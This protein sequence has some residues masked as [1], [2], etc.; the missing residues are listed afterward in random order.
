MSGRRFEL[1]EL[2]L[3]A[4]RKVRDLL[5]QTELGR[6]EASGVLAL[7]G[8]LL[9]I[10]DDTTNIGLIDQDLSP[11]ANNRVIQPDPPLARDKYAGKGYEDI[12]WDP[13]SSSLYLLVESVRHREQLLPRVEIVDAD[14]RRRSQ[15]FLDFPFD[16]DN[17]GMEGLTFTNRDGEPTLVAL[18]EGNRCRGG[19]EGKRPGGGRLQLFRPGSHTCKHLGT[20]KLPRHVWFVDY[21]SVAI[22]GDRIAVLSQ[23]SSALWVGTFSPGSW[24]IADD[25]TCYS[26]P[27]DEKG[28]IQY[29]TAEGVSWLDNN[30]LVVVSDKAKDH[31]PHW[32]AKERR[33]HIFT[34][35]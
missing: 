30:H 8:E 29:G 26:L 22:R 15:V 23:Q 34:L 4:E 21:S 2:Q 13:A 32:Q 14:F 31:Q 35:P 19:E 33:V 16:A 18:C 27:R 25:D 10:F 20:I 6:A 9:V 17:K 1:H 11:T 28:R 7:N 5:P 3:V 24:E 12:A